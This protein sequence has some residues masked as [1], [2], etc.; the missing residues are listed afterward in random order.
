MPKFYLQ[1]FFLSNWF[2]FQIWLRTL[3]F[4][5]QFRVK[6]CFWGWMCTI[7]TFVDARSGHSTP[8]M[9]AG[10]VSWQTPKS[11]AGTMQYLENSTRTSYVTDTM[12]SWMTC[13]GSTERYNHATTTGYLVPYSQ[14]RLSS[15]LGI[16]SQY[17]WM[18][19]K[20][21]FCQSPSVKMSPGLCLCFQ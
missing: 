7:C 6:Y 5:T 14:K 18:K 8:P 13:R 9:L 12:T 20:P 21:K 3:K 1:Q 17:K 11:R 4:N 2:D 19:F 15:G 10:R 16:N